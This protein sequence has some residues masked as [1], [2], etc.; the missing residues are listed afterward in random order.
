MEILD[1]LH[2]FLWDHPM[3]NNCNTYFINGEKKILIDPG[4]YQFFSHVRDELSAL[5]LTPEDMDVVLITHGHPDHIE[6]I[7][8][9]SHMKALIAVS[10]IEMDFIRKIA[11]HYGQALDV[12]DFEPDILL[13]E[14]EMEIGPVTL[15]VV[16]SPGHSPGSV[17]FYWPDKKVLFSG[18]VIFNGGI[19]RT[20]L[21]MGNGEQLKASIRRLAALDTEYVLSGH[22]EPVSGREAVK[23]NFQEIESFWFAYI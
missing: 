11:P 12:P 10:Q 21:P 7:K 3:A 22:G 20:D 23:R 5:S 19:G 13:Q 8:V 1:N 9:F 17:C 4:H 6:S 16:H 2:A 14:G 15:Q 18:D